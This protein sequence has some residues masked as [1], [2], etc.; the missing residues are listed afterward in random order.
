MTRASGSKRTGFPP[1]EPMYASV[2]HG[3][4]DGDDWT[5]EPKYDGVRVLGFATADAARLM[6]RNDNDKAAQFPEVVDALRTLSAALG[7]PFVLDGE[8]VAVVHGQPARFQQLQGRMHTADAST[9]AAL[10]ARAPAAL[11]AF[12]LLLD[13]DDVLLD[14]PW[15]A[16]RA[17]LERLLAKNRAPQLILAESEVADATV[18]MKRARAGRWEGVMAKRTDAAYEPGVRVRHWQKLKIEHRQEFVVGGFTEPRRGR[19][20]FGALLIGYFDDAGRLK[21]AGH[22][23]GGFSRDALADMARRLAPLERDSSPFA[24]PIET[25]EPAHWV[26][27]EVVVEVKFNQWTEDGRLRQPIFVGVRDDKEARA[28]GREAES[29]QGATAAASRRTEQAAAKKSVPG[30]KATA[31]K[32]VAA[33]KKVAALKKPAAPR[34]S[35]VSPVV[36]ELRRIEESGGSGT[37]RFGRGLTLDVSNLDKVYFPAAGYTK[38]DVM[39]Y[40]ATVRNYV[41]PV[42]ADRPLVLRRFPNGIDG[43][44]FYQHRATRV[45]DGVRTEPVALGDDAEAVP[46]LIG[47]DLATLLYTVQLGA[48]SVDPWHGRIDDV[49]AADYAILDLDPGPRASFA[50]VVE[51]ARAVR[52]VLD[53]L[54]LRAALKTSGATGLHIHVPLARGTS[55]E[56]ALIL[57]QLVA[58]RVAVAQPKIATIERKV[59]ARARDAVYV[60]YLQN[61]PGKTVA[62]AYSVRARAGATVSTPLAWDELTDSLDPAVFTIETV[63]ERL[64]QVGDLWRAVMR[65]RNSKRVLQALT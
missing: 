17:R 47:G 43:K 31:A 48:I 62:G 33:T 9:I 13:G 4:P 61:I 64:E 57:G 35:R 7:R 46:F 26:E 34:K 27:P 28:V 10:R 12:D 5:F 16:R 6:T 22:V 36:G 32:Q 20:H 44:A 14:E 18:M 29:V 30:G 23:G 45:P 60:D 8:I 56:T 42:I 54:G 41:L 39:R 50:R 49:H 1:L 63:P 2:G 15:S 19:Q 53:D 24:D 37:A 59:A 40:Y 51:V 3:V 21:S 65:K 25:N 11:I 55:A 38:G 58:T 52:T